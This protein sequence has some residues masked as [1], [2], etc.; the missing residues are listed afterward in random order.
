VAVRETP[1]VRTDRS[2]TD[3]VA[4]VLTDAMVSLA[5][6]TTARYAAA[7]SAEIAAL[8][9][10]DAVEL[11]ARDWHGYEAAPVA[12]A[13]GGAPA[14]A[15]IAATFPVPG[16]ERTPAWLLDACFCPA[17]RRHPQASKTLTGCHAPGGQLALCGAR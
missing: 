17:C 15:R 4:F 14:G 9:G 11:E 1:T 5:G 7:L 2:G 10:A 12:P 3:A 8:G 16:M 13:S 6:L